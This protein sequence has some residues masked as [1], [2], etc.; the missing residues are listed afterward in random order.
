MKKAIIMLMGIA[1]GAG[2]ANAQD[3]SSQAGKLQFKTT[4]YDFGEVAEGPDVVHD[5]VFTNT[6]K[7]PVIISSAAPGCGCTG[8]DWPHEPILPGKE[9][10]IHIVYHTA[11]RPGAFNKDVPVISNSQEAQMFIHIKGT[12]KPKP[13]GVAASVPPAGSSAVLK[14]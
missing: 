13:V 4:T 10:K 1:M 5:F 9:N 12:V 2:V 14:Q 6:G 11:G 8:S 3:K 7:E